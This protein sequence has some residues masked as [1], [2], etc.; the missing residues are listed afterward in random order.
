[1]TIEEITYS[2]SVTQSTVVEDG[3]PVFETGKSPYDHVFTFP[4]VINVAYMKVSNVEILDDG[5]EKTHYVYLQ[6]REGGYTTR[7][8]VYDDSTSDSIIESDIIMKINMPSTAIPSNWE[9]TGIISTGSGR[10][11]NNVQSI[12]LR[13]LNPDLSLY[14][15]SDTGEAT[16]SFDL[17]LGYVTSS[18]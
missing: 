6:V 18:S 3:V 9:S 11:G 4:R 8:A 16:F 14:N 10:E 5:N 7:S 1:M 12:R 17:T 13:V 2:L 15:A